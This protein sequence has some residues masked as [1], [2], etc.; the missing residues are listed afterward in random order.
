M[1]KKKLVYNNYKAFCW[2]PKGIKE[3]FEKWC[4]FWGLDPHTINCKSRKAEIVRWR[5]MFWYIAVGE[6]YHPEALGKY[7][8]TD[9]TCV[10]AAV[11]TENWLTFWQKAYRVN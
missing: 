7:F 1:E 5:H 11:K 10:I 6:G 2:S 4:K 3:R 8:N 9:R